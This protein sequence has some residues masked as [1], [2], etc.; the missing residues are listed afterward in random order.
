MLLYKV[1]GGITFSPKESLKLTLHNE[2]IENEHILEGLLEGAF[3]SRLGVVKKRQLALEKFV[4]YEFIQYH[5]SCDNVD[6]LSVE[7]LIPSGNMYNNLLTTKTKNQGLTK[8]ANCERIKPCNSLV[9]MS[10]F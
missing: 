5:Q 1:R 6:S 9:H 3:K 7:Y 2:V 10:S 4:Y 8:A